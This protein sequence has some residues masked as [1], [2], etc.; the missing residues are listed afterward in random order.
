MKINTALNSLKAKQ[1]VELANL[2]K[3]IRTGED[4]LNKQMKK[5]EEKLHLKF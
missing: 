4:E 2:R 3:K 1:Q 5:D